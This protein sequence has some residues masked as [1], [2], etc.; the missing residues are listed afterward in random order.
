M[1]NNIRNQ[2]IYVTTGDPETVNDP[3]IYAKG[4]LGGR[5]TV[6]QPGVP[7]SP[8][9][10]NY[11]DKTYQYVNTDSSMSVSPF[12]G[13]VAWWADK[14]R[15]RVTTDPTALG[16]GRVAGIFQNAISKGNYGYIQVQ[17]PA[18]VKFVDAPAA[19]PTV[20][21]LSVIPSATA[22]K[23]DCIAAG[24][25]LTYPKLGVSAGVYNAVNCEAIVDLDVPETP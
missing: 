13:A 25:A 14:T 24:G 18:I 15:Y 5:V 17:G 11:R 10:E 16:R 21:G 8:G 7:G 2:T 20:A 12:K 9:A 6:K 23:A 1:P 3:T 4:Q 22:A 19:V